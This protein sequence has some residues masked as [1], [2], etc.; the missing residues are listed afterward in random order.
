[1]DY[2]L[3]LLK[4]LVIFGVIAWGLYY[5]AKKLKK[6]HLSQKSTNGMIEIQDGVTIGMNQG[7]YLLKVGNEQVLVTNGKNGVH[8]IKMNEKKEQTKE[9]FEEMF[10]EVDPSSALKQYQKEFGEKLK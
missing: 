5:T 4:V 6:N 1:M 10:T 7:V 9:N 8:M 2:F 3:S